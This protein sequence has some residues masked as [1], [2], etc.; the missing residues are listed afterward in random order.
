M[1][2]FGKRSSSSITAVDGQLHVKGRL[3]FIM[4]KET[5][6]RFLIDTGAAVSVIPATEIDRKNRSSTAPLHV[7]NGTSIKT[8]GDRSLTLN[9]ELRTNFRWI[10]FIADISMA[11]LG[12]DFLQHFGLTVD[13]KQ[14][15]LI[16]STTK[17]SVSDITSAIQTL[18]IKT[19]QNFDGRFNK[20]IAEFPSVL[21]PTF[22]EVHPEHK[23]THHIQTTGPSVHARPR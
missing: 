12:A 14:R 19:S 18:K 17:L 5:G 23:I 10:F 1:Q 4:E 8:Y 11:I 21:R 16:D 3:F 20:I 13:L 15:R 6:H 2:L 22:T 9:L 7:A